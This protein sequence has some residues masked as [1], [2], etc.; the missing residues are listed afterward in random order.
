MKK[1]HRAANSVSLNF[2]ADPLPLL[3]AVGHA[4][5]ALRRP[6]RLRLRRSLRQARA[7]RCAARRRSRDVWT[8]DDHHRPARRPERRR[9]EVLRRL[10]AEAAARRRTRRRRVRPLDAGPLP[11]RLYIECTAACNIS[12]TEACCA[13]ETGITRTRQA[14]MLDF[15]LF[16]RVIDE[17]GPTL[18]RIDFFNY[19]EAFLHKRAVEMCEYIKTQ[20]PAHLSLHQHQRPGAS[21]RRR[22]GGWCTRASTR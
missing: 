10:P 3:L 7:R 5:H 16:R 6:H 18:G 2:L 17:V 4:G 12:C 8:G 21:P 11:A 22:R 13:P 20:L 19:G 9:L 15:E 1:L 14:G